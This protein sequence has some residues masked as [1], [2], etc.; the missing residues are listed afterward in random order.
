MAIATVAVTV[1]LWFDSAAAQAK[2]IWPDDTHLR[3]DAALVRYVD[4]HTRPGQKLL[5]L[6][7]AADVYYLADRAPAIPYMWE[8]NVQSIPGVLDRARRTLAA[9]EPALVAVVQKPG[10]ARPERPDGRDPR[11]GYRLAAVVDGVPVYVPRRPS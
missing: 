5:L 8:R 9:R 2:A 10:A 3:H 6:W 4:A 7:A 11:L 1:P